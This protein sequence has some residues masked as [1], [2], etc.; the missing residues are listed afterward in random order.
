MPKFSGDVREY[1]IFRADFKYAV[2]ARYSKRDAVTFLRT[3]LEG[4]P[5]ELIK[6]IGSDYDA[7]W[8][9]LDSVYGDPRYVSDTIAQ[10]IAKFKP[11]REGEDS[12][13]FELVHLV[14]RCY[15]TLKEVGLP[16][17]MDNSH[18]LSII[19]QKM[20]VD[21]RKVWSREL[22]RDKKPAS[23]KGLIDWMSI[24]MKSRMRATAPI[25]TTGNNRSIY[26]LTKTEEEKNDSSRHKCWFCKN[27]AHWPD[28]CEKIANLKPDNRLNVAKENHVC[29]SCLKRAGREHRMLNCN[30]R[31]Q[32]TVTEN[33]KQCTS[34]HHP[35]LHQSTKAK[36]GVASINENQEALLPIISA[37]ICGAKKLYKRGNVLFD[38]GAQ[39]SLIKQE[40]AE[41]LGLRGKDASITITKVGGQEE[42]VKTK[43]YKVPVTALDTRKTYSVTAVGI[44]C[45]SD[46]VTEIKIDEIA[47]S[48]RLTKSQ[49]HRGKGSIDLLIGIDHAFISGR[50]DKQDGS[51]LGWVV[52]GSAPGETN[53]IHKIFH[54]KFAM[55]VDLTDFWTTESMGVEVKPCLCKSE[56][57]SRVEHEEKLI[58]ETSCKK[59]GNRWLIPYPWKK[60]PNQLPDN[61]FQAVKRLES[62]ERRLM[63]HPQRAAPTTSK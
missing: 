36:V 29:F 22:Q 4:K 14:R 7:A 39:I 13:F 3:C 37:N 34:F 6:G 30:R 18:M 56:K 31:K 53:K 46:D 63:K 5:L 35:L 43:V 17:D 38:S 19:E 57:L 49:I 45:I 15:N 28:Q 62:T 33:G 27:S 55:P 32:C 42:N 41:N 10:D 48:L 2:E 47:N 44:A 50:Q 51:P 61:R 12:R 21:D 59:V 8:E 11:L 60:N 9:Y 20:C 16:S 24:E 52:F 25:R 23:L 40:T 1:A 26:Y 54:V 58:I